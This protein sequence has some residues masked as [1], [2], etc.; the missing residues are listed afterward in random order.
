L[1]FPIIAIAFIFAEEFVTIVGGPEYIETANVFR[2][3][4]FYGL[5]IPLDRFTG[6]ALDSINM[7]KQNFIKVIYMTLS[8]IIGD[9]IVVFGLYYVVLV[10]ST[11]T[12]FTNGY[13][14]LEIIGET[15]SMFTMITV[16]EMVA[17]IT[18]L[19]TIIGI[20]VGTYFLRKELDI[21]VRFILSGGLMFFRNFL[22]KT[23]IISTNNI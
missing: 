10:V 6:V 4:C 17:I 14:N 12:L 15:A 13:T 20:F 8:N 16:L 19:F 22:K 18:I 2:I 11:I 21:K 5:L 1:L 23:A 7:P 9:A 3:F